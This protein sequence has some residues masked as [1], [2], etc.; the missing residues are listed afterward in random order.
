M[1]TVYVATDLRLERRIALKVMHHHLSDD[2]RFQSRFIQ[3]ARAAARLSDPNVVSVFDQGQDDDIAY[4]VMEYLPGVTLRDLIAEHGRL[5]TAQTITIMHA[6]LSG[7]ASA[8]RAGFIHR[9]VK[10]ENVLLADDGRIKI[11]DFGLARATSANTA[12]G[13]QLLG[14][15]AYLA[16]ELVTQGS[17]DARTDIYAL[18]I[19]LYEML[20]GEQPYQG[21]Q[22]MQIAYQHATEQ[23]PRPSIKNPGVPEPLDELVLWSTERE[24]DER[25]DDAQAMLDRLVEIEH[26]LGIL[27]RP[28]RGTGPGGVPHDTGDL[29]GGETKLLPPQAALLPTG[30]TS[31]LAPTSPVADLAS[32]AALG[33]ENAERLA[34][35][36]RRRS[37]RGWVAAI[38]AFVLVVAAG[39]TGWWFGSGPGSMVLIP[40]F[41]ATT[42]FDDASAEL[43][44]LDLLADQRSASSLDV[45][46]GQL[47]STDP[48]SGDRVY[49][50]DT[51]TL[52]YSTGPAEVTLDSMRGMTADDVEAYATDAVLEVAG[53]PAQRFDA[54]DA[55]TV[56]GISVTSR[57][58]GDP[59]ACFDGCTAHQGDTLSMTLSA[60]PVPDVQNVSIDEAR[61]RLT[62]A[63]LQVAD[64]TQQQYDETIGAGFAIGLSGVTADTVLSPG[65]SVTLIESLGPQPVAV[66]D[67]VGM[68]RD[69][70]VATLEGLGF[71]VSYSGLLNALPGAWV[72]VSSTDP[73]A[74]EMRVP[75]QTTVT[76]SL[77][78]SGPISG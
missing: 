37:A 21:E 13:Q 18:G 3:E 49:P 69:D 74:A 35:A 76:L 4:L 24:P 11:G 16:P 8:H 66:P 27:P 52:T 26:E 15:I 48:G 23:V 38:I 32:P 40:A 22:P 12:T 36:T 9:D 6:V 33:G 54:S 34:R 61:T 44:G 29:T 72:V 41:A 64:E 1:A 78:L 47:I 10:P 68:T 25:P 31:V 55:G 28:P 56:I 7:L 43:A 62:D 65:D 19:M 39:T 70:A 73:A 63:G 75:A 30:A 42:S 20:A 45:P 17:A 58:G 67:V 59:Y 50:G 57:D 77:T 14:T 5:T 51:V 46:S 53:D 71:D 60:G 2:E